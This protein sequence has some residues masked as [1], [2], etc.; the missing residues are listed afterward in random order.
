M[1]PRS[2]KN[3]LLNLAK[4]YP[5]VA[6]TGPRQSGKTTLARS[7]FDKKP[8]VSLE[9]LDNRQFAT[10]DPRRFLSLYPDGAVL[11]EVQR[12]P[13]LFSY[14]QTKV[15]EDNRMGLFI[16]TG[17][18]QFG[19]LENITQTLAGRIAMIQLLPFS[20]SELTSS[21]QRPKTIDELLVKGSYPPI[22]DRQLNPSIWQANY[23]NTYIE[24]DVRQII[25]VRE[26]DTFQRFLRMCAARSGQL[27]NLSALANDC[28]ITHNTAK[29]WV[30]I[31]ETSYIL[32]L[33]RPHHNN[34]NKRLIKSPKLYFHDTGIAAWLCGIHSKE[35]MSIHHMRGPLFETWVINELIKGR[36]NQGLHSN[37]YFWRDRSGNEIDVISEQ[38]SNL[39][40]VEIKSGQTVNTD[41]T[42]GLLRW[43]KLAG[44]IAENPALIYAGDTKQNR[45]GIEIVPWKDISDL[46]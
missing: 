41:F 15:D 24:R 26:L 27:L 3:I 25:N 23:I 35:E 33:L 5:L 17:S 34:L 45:K 39:I 31:L 21:D 37:L 8:Y 16:L 9:D 42:K 28:G 4:G 44:N 38:G 30:S 11:D 18:Q 20:S 29:S 19:L 14:L 6:I 32:L 7:V 1:I 10:D 40:P 13:G 46:I 36:Y 12:C 22:Y 2:A 43:L